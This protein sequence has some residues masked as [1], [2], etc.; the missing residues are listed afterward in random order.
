M[1]N[2]GGATSRRSR[3]GGNNI[4]LFY[5]RRIGIVDKNE[6]PIIGGAKVLGKMGRYQIGVLNMQTEE[7]YALNE[8]DEQKH[9]P[10]ANFTVLR[11]RRE[12]LKRSSVGIMFLNKEEIKSDHYNRSAGFDANFPITDRIVISGAVAGTYGPDQEDDGEIRD[13]QTNN[14]ESIYTNFEIQ[15]IT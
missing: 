12:L 4:R 7:L 11:F 5:S 14:N 8:D 9:Y 15:Q 2:F 10:L 13:M 6:Q 3:G 1:F